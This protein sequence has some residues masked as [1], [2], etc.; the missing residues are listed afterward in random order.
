MLQC[1][2]SGEFEFEFEYGTLQFWM[3]GSRAYDGCCTS[4]N[5]WSSMTSCLQWLGSKDATFQSKGP[6]EKRIISPFKLMHPWIYL[7]RCGLAQSLCCFRLGILI[8]ITFYW[9]LKC[10]RNWRNGYFLCVRALCSLTS[11]LNQDLNSR[12]VW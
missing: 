3:K 10:F 1:C 2:C 8:F 11:L 5:L 7:F 6:M 9:V 4:R 12:M